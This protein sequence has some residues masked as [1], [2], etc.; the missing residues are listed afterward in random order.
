MKRIP[1]LLILPAFFLCAFVLAP[2]AGQAQSATDSVAAV[3]AL[4][5]DSLNL[6][7]KVVY[8]DF[9]ASWCAPCKKSFPWLREMMDKYDGSCFQIVTVN[10]D[11]DHNA[12]LRFLKEVDAPFYVHYDSTGDVAAQFRLEGMPTSLLYGRDG[13]FRVRHEGFNNADT[14]EMEQTIKTL[15]E[16]K[17]RK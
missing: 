6:A 12:A 3:Q 8:L 16:E 7:G 14:L 9:W 10:L 11:R 2:A 1:T 13:M 17:A 15:L 4:V 5:P